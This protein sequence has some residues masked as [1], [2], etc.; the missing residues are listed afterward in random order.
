MAE[1]LQAVRRAL[2]IEWIEAAEQFI[3]Q[4]QFRSPGER[5]RQQD[6]AALPIRQRQETTARER[7][8]AQLRKHARAT[9]SILGTERRERNIG[10]MQAGRDDL[11]DAK[12]PVVMLV[13]IL[14]LRPQVGD[15]VLDAIGI[16]KDLAAVAIPSAGAVSGGRPDVA[17]Q[18]LEQLRLARAVRAAEQPA[19]SRP[20]A[21]IDSAQYRSATEA[22]EYS[23]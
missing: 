12:I 8:D 14:P 20:N 5:T 2:A 22:Q 15:L 6:Q 4:Q 3:E 16:I 19:L 7:S 11:L 1:P 21:P 18:Q 17:G 23:L 9:G 10:A 13:A